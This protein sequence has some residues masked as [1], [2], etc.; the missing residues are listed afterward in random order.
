MTDTTTAVAD[1]A[2]IEALARE[3]TDEDWNMLLAFG[4]LD[5]GL[6][7]GSDEPGDD[8]PL[9]LTALTSDECAALLAYLD[10]VWTKT[11]PRRRTM[12]VACRD[13]E[14]VMALRSPIAFRGL[15]AVGFVRE[16][17]GWCFLT[18]LGRAVL[19]RAK[20]RQP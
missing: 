9:P 17:D 3:L 7:V 18:P 20:E 6:W 11:G 2:A 12:L 19:R 1:R 10:A 8:H 16:D 15:V 13:C 5:H 14:S 4:H